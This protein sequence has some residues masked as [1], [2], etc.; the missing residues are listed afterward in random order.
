M[1]GGVFAA[2]LTGAALVYFEVMPLH[3]PRLITLAGVCVLGSLFPDIDTDSKGQTVFYVAFLAL[4]TWLIALRR[5]E[6]S[7]WLGLLAVIPIIGQHRGW[8]HT[9]WAM[10]LLP[11]PIVLV[12]WLVFGQ[13]WH[14]YAQVYGAFVLGYFSHLALD[15]QFM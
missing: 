10:L 3:W 12:P 14:P 2:A 8:I 13:H 4:D 11:L 7:A 6:L 1:F 5:Y 9:W 15:R